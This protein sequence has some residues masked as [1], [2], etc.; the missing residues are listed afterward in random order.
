MAHNLG[1][2]DTGVQKVMIFMDVVVVPLAPE[3]GGHAND[4][5]GME[6]GGGG[7]MGDDDKANA[8]VGRM[9]Q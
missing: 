4:H 6:M 9:R 1:E 5:T 3:D 2:M 8:I 7:G